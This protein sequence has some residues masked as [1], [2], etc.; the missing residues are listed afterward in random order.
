MTFIMSFGI[1]TD[2]YQ[3]LNIE[4]KIG[5]YYNNISGKKYSIKER[6]LS[7]DETIN[8]KIRNLKQSF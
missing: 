1:K 7:S 2:L 5:F 3:K 4:T 8:I 6:Q